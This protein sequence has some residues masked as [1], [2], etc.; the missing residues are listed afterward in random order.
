MY[1]V[2]FHLGP[3]TISS[4]GFFLS[5]A[6]LAA[7]FTAW[8]LAKAYD[9][10]EEKVIDL[11]IFT[12]LGGLIFA[13]IFFVIINWSYFGFDNFYKIF[14]I[15]LYPGLS[16]WGGFLGGLFTLWFL[17]KRFKLA[18]WQVA[19]FAAVS[20]LLGLAL[21]DIGCFL[22]GCYLGAPSNSFLA[23]PV[24]G[25][26]GKRL[27]VSLFESLILFF[28]FFRLFGQ[29]IKFH[30]AGKILALSLIYLGLI[31]FA[32]QFFRAGQGGENLI[33]SLLSFGLLVSGMIIFYLR[34]KRNMIED[35][36]NLI[37]T[38]FS[39]KKR[40]AVVSSL[41]KDWYNNQ[42]DWKIKL[43]KLKKLL[44]HLPKILKRRLNVKSNPKDIIEN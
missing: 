36:K 16:F 3:F 40:Q 33:S 35:L 29:V 26:I 24:V 34:S 11:A 4:F 8:R 13:R 30:V 32:L 1:P 44:S 12:F 17:C 38:P 18:F 9:L 37:Q 25:V 2:L 43:N 27:P 39:P 6:V 7:V 10:D 15:N 23:M 20:F 5:L 28:I 14:L 41:K 42:V 31:R 21:S 19:D 22:G